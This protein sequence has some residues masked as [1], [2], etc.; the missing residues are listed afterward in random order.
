MT[1]YTLVRW[2][3]P[4]ISEGQGHILYLAF[5][6]LGGGPLTLDQLAKECESRGYK[7]TFK[8]EDNV[9]RSVRYHLNKWIELGLVKEET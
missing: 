2:S 1:T 5:T 8:T 3:R 9:A 7:A 6:A 4:T